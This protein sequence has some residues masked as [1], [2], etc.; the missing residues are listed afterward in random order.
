MLNPTRKNLIH[1]F[2]TETGKSLQNMDI[3]N[4]IDGVEMP[5]DILTPQV[6]YSQLKSTDVL[7]NY[8]VSGNMAFKLETDMRTPNSK[9]TIK[10]K[11]EIPSKKGGRFNAVATTGNGDM[12]I[13]TNFGEIKLY[14]NPERG[15]KK[16]KT[17]I[18]QL[19]SEVIGV[20]V[21]Y[22]G[23]WVVWTTKEFLALL[24]VTFEKGGTVYSGFQKSIAS[25]LRE[26]CLI[27]K[28]SEKDVA[29]YN[30]KE[31]NF[32]PAKFDNNPGVVSGGA[33]T[34][35]V[36]TTG[37]YIVKWNFKK[38]K[39]DYAKKNQADSKES[40]DTSVHCSV[41]EKEESNV[42]DNLFLYN[43][44]VVVAATLD[45]QFTRLTLDS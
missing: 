8:G 36:T 26:N 35:I 30:I 13:G 40:M 31:V 42:I 12:V 38:L 43:E 3:S 22:D 24:R 15:W 21:S 6:K 20:D 14:S 39:Q 32:A 1:I 2:D 11:T 37:P 34:Y 33:E 5:I 45:G 4:T 10:E 41:V 44:D 19:T 7:E 29:T 16:A 25:E 9:V 17:N 23:E 18:N 28:L 27:L